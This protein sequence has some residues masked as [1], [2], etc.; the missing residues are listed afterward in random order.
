V[1][2]SKKRPG[3]NDALLAEAT[4]IVEALKAARA[5]KEE[6]MEKH[7]E[8]LEKIES[9][10]TAEKLMMQDLAALMGRVTFHEGVRVL[11]VSGGF[12][13][14]LRANPLY[15]RAGILKYAKEL[16]AAEVLKLPA[17]STVRELVKK[18]KVIPAV[19]EFVPD[20]SEATDKREIENPKGW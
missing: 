14:K 1:T 13:F 12:A 2:V 8:V 20:A 10:N 11:P 3:G 7:K 17:A 19:L 9:F 16:H 15:C 18:G 5:S 4:K 6:F